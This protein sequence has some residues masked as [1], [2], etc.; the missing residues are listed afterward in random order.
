LLKPAIYGTSASC[1]ADESDEAG[2]VCSVLQIGHIILSF[3][4]SLVRHSE[5]YECRQTSSNGL[6]KFFLQ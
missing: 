3:R 2:V 5:Q 4:I 6:V 1:L